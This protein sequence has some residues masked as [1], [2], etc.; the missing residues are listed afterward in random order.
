MLSS[1]VRGRKINHAENSA[2]LNRVHQSK[3]HEVPFSSCLE[4]F[5][6]PIKSVFRFFVYDRAGLRKQVFIRTPCA[7][8]PPIYN[9]NLRLAR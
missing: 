3:D 4:E 2:L 6:G 5:Y 7:L 1:A 8:I 9:A